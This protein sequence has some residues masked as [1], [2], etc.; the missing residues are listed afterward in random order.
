[1]TRGT[2]LIAVQA[3][4]VVALTAKDKNG[5]D[6]ALMQLIT[7]VY[8]AKAPELAELPYVTI[9][10]PSET[11][12]DT[13]GKLGQVVKYQVNV[14]WDTTAGNSSL[15]VKEIIGAV[16]DMLDDAELTVTGYESVKVAN[17]LSTD[18]PDPDN[19]HWHGVMQFE[20]HVMQS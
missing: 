13:F 16:N 14:W 1:M 7:G 17:V 4:L 20:I 18:Y 6:N 5:D 10:A 11:S 9:D 3:A 8:D 12:W 19:E 2:S 15:A